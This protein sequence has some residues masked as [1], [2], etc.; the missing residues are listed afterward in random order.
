LS[1]R[2]VIVEDERLVARDIAQILQDEGYVICA[3]ASDGET[4]IKKIV[5]AQRRKIDKKAKADKLK[6]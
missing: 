6:K 3:I 2:V 4:A 1:T 5:I